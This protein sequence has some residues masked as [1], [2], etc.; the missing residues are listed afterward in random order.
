MSDSEMEERG[1]REGEGEC[2]QS[3][4]R[5]EGLLFS[6]FEEKE[7]LSKIEPD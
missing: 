6:G 5:P 1:R 3:G 2:P 7:V 4:R